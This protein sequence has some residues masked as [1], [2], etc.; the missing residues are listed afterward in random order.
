M[1]KIILKNYPSYEISEDGT[2]HKLI[3][4]RDKHGHIRNEMIGKF[5]RVELKQSK[6]RTNGYFRVSL[7][8]KAKSVHS[9][10]ALA[11]IGERKEGFQINHIDGNKE[12][13]HY[14]N[15]EYVTASQNMKHATWMGLNKMPL[16]RGIMPGESNPGCK[17]L[18]ET[19]KKIKDLKN[20]IY[21]ADEVAEMFKVK[22]RLV[23]AI[24]NNEIWKHI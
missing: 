6:N 22:R 2:I 14:T 16:R 12:N 20:G 9:L 5:K 18:E 4:L 7:N 8:G 23:Y 15:L 21:F 1:E 3:Q 24:W 19:A 17:I 13:N 11:F 10:V